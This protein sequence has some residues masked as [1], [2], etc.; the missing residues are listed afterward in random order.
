M[1]VRTGG[2]VK[3]VEPG[4]VLAPDEMEG[5]AVEPGDDERAIVERPLDAG[6]R[7]SRRSR[8]EREPEPARILRLHREQPLGDGNRVSRRR[9]GEELRLEALGEHAPIMAQTGPSPAAWR[10]RAPQRRLSSK[11]RGKEVGMKG[12]EKPK[13]LAKKAPQKTL[14]EK[15]NEKRAAAAKKTI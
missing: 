6:R 9:P 8:P 5:A 11:L 2:V 14:K 7:E 1:A 4:I 10:E 15:R 3:R 13:K 12:S